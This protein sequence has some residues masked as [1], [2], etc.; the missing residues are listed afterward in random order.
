VLIVG[1]TSAIALETAR[2]FAADGARLFLCAR[3]P[4]R[5]AAVADDLRVRGASEAGTAVL[6]VA[7]FP[8]QERAL[9]QAVS[10]LGA[11]DVALV[12]HGGL[13]DQ[14]R[15]EVDAN[16]ALQSLKVNF[17]GTVALLTI[18]ANRLEA[19]RSGCL[20]V[21]TSVAG[22]RGRGSNYVYGAAKGGLH[23]FLQGLR[24]R[25]Y[26]SGVA[27]VEIKPGFVD[28]PMTAHLRKNLLFASPRRVG[29]AVYRAILRR[30]DIV[31]V[32]WFWRPILTLV[33][34]LPERV[35][36]RLTL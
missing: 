36:K 21:I 15:C 18:L 27:V 22:D 19:Q 2:A 5:L 17:S 7:D 23:V 8:A 28:T 26:R 32:P 14:R 10:K 4:A 24:N 3:D 25:L 9:E 34:L 13:A 11:I 16:A 33:T 30:R 12:A 31:Y 1:A 20:A 35:F 29:R 6:D